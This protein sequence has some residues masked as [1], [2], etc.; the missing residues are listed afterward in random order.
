MSKPFKIQSPFKPMGDQPEAI[1]QLVKG[2]QSGARQQVLLGATGTGKTR[3]SSATIRLSPPSSLKSFAR[4][5]P[6][7]LFHTSSPTTTITNPKPIFLNVTFTLRRTRHETTTS[8]AFDWLRP[9]V[10]S[11]AEMSSW[12]PASPASMAWDLPMN[13]RGRP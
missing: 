5:S 7:T 3:S 6:K 9:A 12:S 13:T 8:I 11:A 2:I 10:C 1:R 4:C